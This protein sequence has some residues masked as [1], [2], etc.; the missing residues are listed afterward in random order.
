MPVTTQHAQ[1]SAIQEDWGACRDAAAGS[2]AIKAQGERYLP[3]LSGMSDDEYLAYK[4]RALWYGATGRTIQGMAGC[5]FRKPPMFEVPDA[6]TPDL[7]DITLTG[8]PL[9]DFSRTI[10]REVLEVGRFGVLVDMGRD[11]QPQDGRTVPRPYWVGYRAEQIINWATTHR[12]GDTVLSMVVLQETHATPD[13]DDPFTDKQ[14]TQYR[15]LWLQAGQY[16]ID[17]YR[18]IQG[19]AER[20]TWAIAE[21]ITPMFRGQ[22][23]PYIPFQFFNA[24]DISP[25]VERPPLLDLADLNL[26]HYRNSADHEH[27][28]H[29]TALPTP[30][31]A[32]FP[33]DTVLKIGSSVAWVSNDVN[34]KAG[35]LEYTGDGLGTL[36]RSMDRKERL[37]AVLGARMLE[38]QKRAAESA[39]SQRIRGAGEHSVL[40]DMSRAV[41]S[42]ITNALRWHAWWTGADQDAVTASL[43]QEFVEAAM[44]PAE[45]AELLKAWQGGAIAHETL[46]HNLERGGLTRPDVP[47]EEEKVLIDQQAPAQLPLPDS[48][49]Q[50]PF[51]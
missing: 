25:A 45:L 49:P 50:E 7:K 23:L 4:T 46:Y 15:V 42:G 44:G 47:F 29:F 48:D 39:D 51:S 1:Y 6:L 33:T 34:A 43:N 30:W 21:T 26:S 9:E 36:E 17:L 40:A 22:P 38:E 19:Q 11:V 35:M 13:P 3:K 14:E 37:M 20:E 31:V 24:C 27:G 10:I 18:K 5:I 8:M 28:I 2:K 16:R 32:G 41:S 12:D